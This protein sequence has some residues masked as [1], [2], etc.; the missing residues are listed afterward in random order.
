MAAYPL[1][2][3]DVPNGLELPV[4]SWDGPVRA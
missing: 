4:W 2:P 3:D 1:S